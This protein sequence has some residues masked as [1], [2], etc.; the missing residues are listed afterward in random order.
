MKRSIC[1]IPLTLLTQFLAADDNKAPVTPISESEAMALVTAQEVASENAKD[2]KVTKL[3]N[4]EIL[5]TA[6]A[7][8]GHKRVVFNRIEAPISEKSS[9]LQTQ[10]N[11]IERTALPL[12]SGS[13]ETEPKEYISVT[14]S[15]TVY[16][17]V[18]T[19]LW[20]NY[21]DQRYRVF[22]NQ[23]LFLLNG[24]GEFEDDNKRYSVFTLLA[25]RSREYMRES[26]EWIPTAEDFSE[27]T[28]EYFVM[29]IAEGDEL[30]P[31]AFSIIDTMLRYLSE[32]RAD[33]QT[34]HDNRLKL[35]EA[36]EAYLKLNPPK[37]DRDT[38]INFRPTGKSSGRF[39]Q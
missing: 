28:I 33:L 17:E 32:N 8:L 23:N 37:T 15:G 19:E 20:W 21:G 10:A 30:N 5:E 7:N 2:E 13:F 29:D 6:V 18:I 24:I 38:V 25:P 14:L 22:V 27:D 3:W 16:D 31:D 35:H 1:L 26:D 36:R 39:S 11:E 12:E 9:E 34:A 4:A